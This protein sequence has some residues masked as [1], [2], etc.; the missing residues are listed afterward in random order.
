[1]SKNKFRILQNLQYRLANLE[2]NPNHLSLD[3]G[4]ITIEGITYKKIRSG[5]DGI[6]ILV[7]HPPDAPQEPKTYIIKAFTHKP[8]KNEKT[9]MG[10]DL[11]TAD[12]AMREWKS[13]TLLKGHPNVPQIIST[14]LDT[15]A[16]EVDNVVFPKAYL[17]REE[18]IE[19]IYSITSYYINYLGISSNEDDTKFFIDYNL[20]TT[21]AK[22]LWGQVASLTK[23]LRDHRIYH[24]D[25]DSCN[26]MIQMPS[27]RLFLLDFAKADIPGMQSPQSIMNFEDDE[28]DSSVSLRR[29][30]QYKN[31]NNNGKSDTRYKIDHTTTDVL[32]YEMMCRWVSIAVSKPIYPQLYPNLEEENA[33]F[34]VE[35]EKMKLAMKDNLQTLL[36]LAKPPMAALKMN[37]KIYNMDKKIP[38]FWQD[39]LQ[40]PVHT[41]AFLDTIHPKKRKRIVAED[42]K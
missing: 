32:D 20:R 39:K 14:E 24:R 6:I 21:L 10:L 19:N 31:V 17:I 12:Q 2:L 9:R 18:Y 30:T 3:L 36:P 27:L 28:E 11:I 8:T 4:K 23:A 35:E 13:L 34:K 41:Q 42:G 29:R 40:D 38:L 1:M 33:V 26:F 22:Y 16:L 15:C 7:K 37:E 5:D 25:V